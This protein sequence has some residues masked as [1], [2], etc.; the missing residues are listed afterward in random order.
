M[1]GKVLP[2]HTS[3]DK[4]VCRE[5]R[6][7][8]NHIVL[9]MTNKA[10]HH[11]NIAT[12]QTTFTDHVSLGTVTLDNG[13]DYPVYKGIKIILTRNCNKTVGFVNGQLATGVMMQR[14]SIIEKT[15]NGQLLTV[16]PLTQETDDQPHRYH[17]SIP[18]YACT[19]S[20]MQGQTLSN[21]IPWFDT[22]MLPSGTAY[23]AIS[24]VCTLSNLLFLYP[25]TVQHFVPMRL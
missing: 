17:P 15:K 5:I 21:I 22:S 23:I 2:S 19:I 18:A 8:P 24:R 9:T 25:I 4:D 20:K 10:A 1:D 13:Y 3:T 11:I 16:Y 12:L 6:K 14:Q 7:F